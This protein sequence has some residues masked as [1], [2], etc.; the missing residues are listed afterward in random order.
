MKEKITHI[1]MYVFSALGAILEFCNS[2]APVT[3]NFPYAFASEPNVT[4]S[5]KSPSAAITSGIWISS[6]GGTS[7]TIYNNNSVSMTINIKAEAV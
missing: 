1:G 4:F 2:N 5:P 6:A 3:W 7:V